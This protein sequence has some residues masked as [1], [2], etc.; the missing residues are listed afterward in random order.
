MA[1]LLE[2]RRASATGKGSAALGA[3]GFRGDR[4]GHLTAGGKA[5]DRDGHATLALVFLVAGRGDDEVVFEAEDGGEFLADAFHEFGEL[6]DHDIEAGGEVAVFEVGGGEF[7]DALEGG[8]GEEGFEAV[9]DDE[10][11]EVWRGIEADEN[12]AVLAVFAVIAG[13]A[14]GVEEPEEVNAEGELG[15]EVLDEN[16]DPALREALVEGEGGLVEG[17]FVG[18]GEGLGEVGESGGGEQG[19]GTEDAAGFL[20]VEIAA[21]ARGRGFGQGGVTEGARDHDWQS[22]GRVLRQPR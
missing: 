7:E 15:R 10:A 17:F 6:L 22:L 5:C 12:V 16:E 20:Q 21:G 8:L 4:D 2:G 9:A 19:H 18:G 14:G 3:G 13:E 1:E 11:G